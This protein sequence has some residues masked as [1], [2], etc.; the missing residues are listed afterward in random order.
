MTRIDERL[1]ALGL[2]L[3]PP[4]SPP[5]GVLRKYWISMPEVAGCSDCGMITAC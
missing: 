4:L 1:S 2:V 3:P 5:A